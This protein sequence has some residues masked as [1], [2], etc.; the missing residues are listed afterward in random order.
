MSEARNLGP[1]FR[2]RV[3]SNSMVFVSGPDLVAE[4][5]SPER[6]VKSVHADLVRLRDI[7]GDG[8]FTAFN[9]EPNW[10]KAH[11]ILMPAFSLDAMR[12]YHS[13]MVTAARSLMASWDKH[14]VANSSA[15]VPGDMTR[16][17]FD[18]IGMCGFGYDFGSFE[19]SDPHPFVASMIRALDHAQASNELPEI[20]NRLKTRSNERYSADIDS[21]KDLIRTIV[22]RRR[23]EA[24]ERTDDLLGRMLNT[25]DQ[26]TGEPL[27]DENIR[28]QVMT[29]LIA[30]H[31]TTGGALSFALHYLAKNPAVLERA[32]REVDSL[33]GVD[34]DVDPSYEDIGKL[35]YVRQVLNEALRLWPTA[36]GYAVSPLED[37]VVGRKYAFHTDEAMSILIPALHRV[38]E[39]GDSVD[40]FDPERFSPER[41]A[42]R[43]VHLY[44]PFGNG[45]RA[46]I[47]RQFALHEATLVLGMLI[48]RFRLDDRAN[49]QLRIGM[50]LTIKPEGLT[51]FP[52]RRRPSDR[53]QH[54]E[55]RSETMSSTTT[56]TQSVRTRARPRGNDGGYRTVVVAHGSNLGTSSGIA[57]DLAATATDLGFESN[58]A[59]L[60]D[61]IDTLTPG[62]LLVVVA[63]SYN[64]RPTDNAARFVQWVEKLEPGSLTGIDFAVLGVGDRNWAATYQQIPTLID[65]RLRFAGANRILDR[66]EA[67]VAGDFAGSVGRW[68]GELWDTVV[69]DAAHDNHEDGNDSDASG[70]ALVLERVDES[71]G[72]GTELARHYRLDAVTV[73]ESSE[74]VDMDHEWSRSKRL[75]RLS[76]PL[77]ITYRTGDRLAVLPRN[78]EHTIERVGVRFGL[79]LDSP[80][81][82]RSVR[83]I[84]RHLPQGRATTAREILRDYVELQ[85]S[86]GQDDVR[87]LAEHCSCPPERAPLNELAELRP[88][89]F[90]SRVTQTGISVLDLLERYQ[91]I[92]LPF[93]VFL[94]RMPN[95]RMRQYSISS[96]AE[97]DPGTVDL[98]V[99]LLDAPHRSNSSRTRY[100]GTA[101]HWLSSLRVEDTIYAK[102]VPCSDSFRLSVDDPAVLVSAG[103]GLAPFRG[104]VQ[105]RAHARSTAP[106]LNYFGCDHPDVDYLHR[107]ELEK[108]EAQGVVSMRP[109]FALDPIGGHRFVQDRMVAENAEIWAILEAG[110]HIRVC[111]DGARVGVGVDSALAEIFRLRSGNDDEAAARAWV[112]ELRTSGRYV[113]DVWWQ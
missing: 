27:D 32:Q 112:D 80:F 31:E 16:L 89:E 29:F 90:S 74:M 82:I 85:D 67:D 98:M 54:V 101:S 107:E 72:T 103:T 8:L 92:E 70:P 19:K 65:S 9:E 40:A 75:I 11:D 109:T 23:S 96:S 104:M 46:C 111:G 6:F 33:W 113:S 47:G 44:K 87:I 48:H 53:R 59:P 105:D 1:I 13:K 102:V 57:G 28:H 110:G 73:L 10:R 50:T 58:V 60:D 35:S 91:S 56:A 100:R 14:A 30:G 68:A 62:S 94:E 26:V 81:R 69:P 41:V 36:P 83:R 38:P 78:P 106:L 93:P 88:E 51:L 17:T 42:E 108:A 66:G 12:G 77:G 22:E 63:S 3:F 21:M 2:L 37:T 20:I 15:D 95:L 99:S 24:P 52:V 39:W 86:A 7:G 25:V 18:T 71:P 64:G 61:I 49:Y 4:L 45:E 55:R 76:L 84:G 79:D 43:P 5:S 34:D 97:T